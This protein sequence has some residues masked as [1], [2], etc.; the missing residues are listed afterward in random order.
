MGARIFH[1][2]FFYAACAAACA[3]QH[4]YLAYS[5]LTGGPATGGGENQGAIVTIDG[6]WFGAVRADSQVL[7]AGAP[8]YKILQWSD[9]KISFQIGSQARSGSLSVHTA[10]GD[11]NTLPFV[12]RGGKI[13]FVATNGHDVGGGTWDAPWRTIA[14]AAGSMRPG[15]ITYVL[16][17]VQ[18]VELSNYH[19]S[20]SIQNSGSAD[21]PIALVAYPAAKP[22][23]GDAAGPEFGARTPAIKGGPF[24]DW[25][26][27]GF[28]M[29]GGNTALQLN[30]VQRWRIV[31]NDFSCPRGDG[32]SACVEVSGSSSIVFLGNS[33]HDAGKLGASK[34]Y[35][36]VYFTTD[37][38][39]IDLG[40]N[41]I[42]HNHSC[43]GIQFHSSP[44]SANTGFN[45]YD[46]RIHDNEIADQVC[47]GINLATIDPSKGRIAIYNNLIARVGTGPAPPDGDAD[48]ACI[49]SPGIVN[50]GP[51]GSGTVEIFNNTLSDCG[52][53]G[54][55]LAGAFA[56]GANSPVLLLENNLIAQRNQP[57]FTSASAVAR[58]RG[59][60]NLWT[61]AG[62]G[63]SAT[64]GNLQGDPEF[65]RTPSPF[66]LLP[67]SPAKHAASGC[68]VEYD[69]AGSQRD[70][71]KGCSIGAY[72]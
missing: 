50:R 25:I 7:L 30:G 35:Q 26:I 31:D 40:W 19:A 63:P 69:I 24:N 15:D 21:L 70:P 29:R 11:S 61:G 9:R 10:R 49:S 72:E 32:S 53:I 51:A 14:R 60:A 22:V 43:R 54:G 18:Q 64:E 38:N 62:Q 6:A 41:R 5:D 59:N 48:Y 58:V 52:P 42:T 37:S 8:V 23:I 2:L 67:G 55:P 12:V 36:S 20:L 3:A 34:H 33:V 66:A 71:A 17:G 44:V 16:D 47:D 1:V 56:V 46:L 57:Y 45:Q 68:P 13:H 39:H 4:P 27:A 28:V 65:A